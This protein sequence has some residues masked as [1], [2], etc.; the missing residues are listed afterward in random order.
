MSNII[1]IF[2]AVK[3][4]KQF[5]QT[6]Y[7]RT[8]LGAVIDKEIWHLIMPLV[9]SCQHMYQYAKNYETILS[10]LWRLSQTDYGRTIGHSDYRVLPV[11]PDLTPGR[12]RSSS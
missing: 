5:S 7:G 9:R 11:S 3:K 10:G 2:R 1:N 6:D 12:A 8:C 4:L